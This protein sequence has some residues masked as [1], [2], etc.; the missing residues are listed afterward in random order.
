[1]SGEVDKDAAAG[2]MLC[3]TKKI[4]LGGA[5]VGSAI[6]AFTT[7]WRVCSREQHNP[8][9]RDFA[10]L[11]PSAIDVSAKAFKQAFAAVDSGA[12]GACMII[13]PQGMPTLSAKALE[14]DAELVTPK[15]GYAYGANAERQQWFVAQWLDTSTELSV[16]VEYL[17]TMDG[18]TSSLALPSQKKTTILKSFVREDAPSDPFELPSLEQ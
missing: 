8:R 1:M 15:K 14:Q 10:E 6:V 17:S 16:R 2:A 7:F 11:I 12:P 3:T 4:V 18:N 13:A 9:K 5:I